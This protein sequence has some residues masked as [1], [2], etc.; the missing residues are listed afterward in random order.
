MFDVSFRAPLQRVIDAYRPASNDE[1]GRTW[2]DVLEEGDLVPVVRCAGRAD[3]VASCK[4][5][6]G[7]MDAALQ[8]RMRLPIFVEQ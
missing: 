7:A 4:S 6:E 5:V 2:R 8:K 1:T 3:L